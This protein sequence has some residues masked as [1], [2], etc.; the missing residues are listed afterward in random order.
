MGLTV[1]IWVRGNPNAIDTGVK[2][3]DQIF[4]VLLE[5]SIFVGGVIAAFFDNTLPG[6]C[7]TRLQMECC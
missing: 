1:P 5:T 2:E 3:L 6:K 7:N 4:I